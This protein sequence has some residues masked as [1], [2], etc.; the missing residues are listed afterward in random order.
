MK[1]QLCF[2]FSKRP[3]IGP[4]W[5]S[6]PISQMRSATTSGIDGAVHEDV[7][8][9]QGGSFAAGRLFAD[10]GVHVASH[11]RRDGIATA[12]ASNVCQALQFD[13]LVPVWGTSSDNAAS[14]AI[15]DTLGFE[16]VARLSYLV[17][18]T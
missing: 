8:V 4:A 13:G 17:R 15:A 2:D 10:V 18:K 3:P 7:I 14:L 11:H 12:C 6:T 5:K 9:G 1:V 16:E